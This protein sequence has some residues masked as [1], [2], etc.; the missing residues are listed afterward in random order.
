[1][2]FIAHLLDRK[3]IRCRGNADERRLGVANPATP[4]GGGEERND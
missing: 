2:E 1:V 3:V 4:E